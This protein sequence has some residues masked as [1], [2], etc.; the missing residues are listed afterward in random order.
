MNTKIT[1][2]IK[3]SKDILNFNPPTFGG[4][5]LLLDSKSLQ[6][7]IRPETFTRYISVSIDRD[8]GP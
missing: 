1:C 8:N 3:I 4:V 2:A 5:A 7:N 6:N